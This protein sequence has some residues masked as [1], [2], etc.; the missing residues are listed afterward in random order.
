MIAFEFKTSDKG[1]VTHKVYFSTDLKMDEEDI[2]K[3]YRSHFHIE[4][5]CYDG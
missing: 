3:Y 5:L 2:I 1:K 4:F